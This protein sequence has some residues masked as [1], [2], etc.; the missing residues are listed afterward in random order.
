VASEC[1]PIFRTWYKRL[2]TTLD[3]TVDNDLQTFLETVPLFSTIPRAQLQRFAAIFEPIFAEKGA[4]ICREGEPGDAMY[5]IKSGAVGV[6]V[7]RDHTEM[8]VNYLH[9]GDFLGKWRCWCNA[10]AT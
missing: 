1:T 9:R 3:V 8:F 2:S 10:S 5:I 4:V 6:Y 7:A